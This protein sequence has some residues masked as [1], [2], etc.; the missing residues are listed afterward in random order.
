M[1]SREN[2]GSCF[3]EMVGPARNDT[4]IFPFGAAKGAWN[5]ADLVNGWR[6]SWFVPQAEC[7]KCNGRW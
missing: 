1:R 3:I 5:A 4:L 7:V 6:R 2:H